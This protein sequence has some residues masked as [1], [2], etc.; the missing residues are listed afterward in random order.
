MRILTKI[1]A[2]SSRAAKKHALRTYTRARVLWLNLTSSHPSAK[3]S[4]GK[5]VYISPRCFIDLGTHPIIIGDHC[6]LAAGVILSSHGGAITIGRY[7]LIQFN[8]IIHGGVEIG[9]NCL[10]AANCIIVPGD[11]NFRSKDIPIRSQGLL[12]PRIHIAS[13]VWLG[14]GAKIMPG[15]IV[16]QGTVVGAGSVLKGK[17]DEFGIYVGSLAKKIGSRT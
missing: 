14:I 6:S 12:M 4:V 17:T 13:D 2:R 10:L 16:N 9:D 11:H 3:L 1:L 15:A 8:V 7:N 5:G